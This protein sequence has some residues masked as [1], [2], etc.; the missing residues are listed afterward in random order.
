MSETMMKKSR[1][2]IAALSGTVIIAA[3]TMWGCGTK[4]YD[5]PAPPAPAP[6]LVT[7]SNN[8]LVTASELKGWI[9]S[10]LVNNGSG[11][12]VVILD[13]T[14]RAEYDK[15]HIP[16]A[17]F[18]D[19]AVDTNQNRLEGIATIGSMVPDGAR[20]D[21]LIQR[22]GIDQNTTIVFTTSKTNPIIRATRG[23][24]VF[25]YWGFPKE[26]LK[27]LDGRNK[28]FA[29]VASLTSSEPVVKASTY[30]VAPNGVNSVRADL[31]AS[32]GE[33]ISAVGTN[34]AIFDVRG[35]AAGAYPNQTYP[36]SASYNGTNFN[37]DL[38]DGT[39]YLVFEGHIKGAKSLAYA[40]LTDPNPANNDV[41]KSKVDLVTL[42][43]TKNPAAYGD[44]NNLPTT[45]SGCM[46]GTQSTTVFFVMDAILGWP[47]QV[48]DGSWGQWGVMSANAANGGKLPAGSVWATDTA[49]LS[50]VISYNV[51]KTLTAATAANPAVLLTTA[52]IV[53]PILDTY[54]LTKFKLSS[55][56]FVNG[57][58]IETADKAYRTP[59]PLTAPATPNVKGNSGG[60]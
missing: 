12:K 22:A 46:S 23:Y 41:F 21:K 38:I 35:A 17:I 50:E 32:L 30:G 13:V 48:Y 60:C 6:A 47:V 16:G 4:G 57:N 24:F 20:M 42:F 29:A 49:A 2:V 36:N 34:I 11:Q 14:T 56:F 52:N 43:Q 37:T 28:T 33:M 19:Q 7:A 10:G 15:E 55:D 9:D 3:F 44:L 45:Y 51:G 18:A 1:T 54:S 59:A 26:R 31:R 40:E 8:A 53:S 25:R 5:I 58:Q 39:K 27:L